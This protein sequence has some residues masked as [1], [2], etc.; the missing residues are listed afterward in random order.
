MATILFSELGQN[1]YQASLSSHISF[2]Q[3]WW[4][5]LE[6]FKILSTFMIFKQLAMAAILFFKMRLKFFRK[7]FIA[8]NIPCKCGEYIFIN[9]WDIKVYAKTWRTDGHTDDRTHRCTEG[10]YN[11]PT[12]ASGCRREIKTALNII[13]L[14]SQS[15]F[16]PSL[17]SSCIPDS[18][19]RIDS[20]ANIPLERDEN[21][22][23]SRKVLININQ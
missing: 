21:E 22:P 4:S 9:E 17:R 3:I 13:L 14:S 1:Y 20:V 18:Q 10:F 8:I 2:V 12:T 7:V 11:L 23:N 5:Q 6:Y 16:S 15:L 19:R